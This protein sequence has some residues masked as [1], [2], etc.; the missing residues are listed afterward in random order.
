MA[1]KPKP[2]VKPTADTPDQIAAIGGNV[3][4]T[5]PT[6]TSTSTSTT[7]SQPNFPTGRITGELSSLDTRDDATA[8]AFEAISA[9]RA[10]DVLSVPQT[11]IRTAPAAASAPVPTAHIQST[12]TGTNPIV[13]QRPTVA[14]HAPVPTKPSNEQVVRARAVCLRK[15]EKY[16]KCFGEEM[17]D[18]IP[19]SVNNLTIEQLDAL[20]VSCDSKLGDSFGK[21]AIGFGMITVVGIFEEHGLAWIPKGHL[22]RGI[23]ELT[24]ACVTDPDES[25][26]FSRAL[27]RIAIKYTGVLETSAELGI[28][29]AML[30]VF[31]HIKQ[32]NTAEYRKRG[33]DPDVDPVTGQHAKPTESFTMP[34]R[35]NL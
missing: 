9:K 5:E 31:Q 27:N 21:E 1:P 26:P 15:L 6:S 35:S 17:R 19:S 18:L 4:H 34:S 8:R 28:V 14:P 33:M 20:C 16:K 11:P 25:T 2:T 30:Q 3:T 32:V 22:Y 10:S 7:T 23:T 24:E 29:L 13:A 12:T